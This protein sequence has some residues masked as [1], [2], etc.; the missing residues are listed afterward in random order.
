[1]IV[2]GE[3]LEITE[4]LKETTVET[5]FD[6]GT[7]IEITEETEPEIRR[8]E[9][10][11]TES[12]SETET[13][14][15]EE[16][17]PETQMTKEAETVITEET[18]SETETETETETEAI[19]ET[20]PKSETAAKETET[21]VTEET[22]PES[23]TQTKIQTPMMKAAAAPQARA[24]AVPGPT[25]S[26]ST[27]VDINN[28]ENIIIDIDDQ[29]RLKL[30]T[31]KVDGTDST[32]II[33]TN[34]S[35]MTSLKIN[36]VNQISFGESIN[37]ANAKNSLAMNLAAVILQAQKVLLV[38]EGSFTWN[39]KS[40]DVLAAPAAPDTLNPVTSYVE[41]TYKPHTYEVQIKNT[42]INASENVHIEATN[43]SRKNDSD[44]ADLVEID[45][46]KDSGW[47][48]LVNEAKKQLES[49]G[50]SAK[51][52]VNELTEANSF[53]VTVK[54]EIT[55]ILVENSS[56][57]SDELSLNTNT[58]VHVKTMGVGV[59]VA[60][61]VILADS[62]ISIKNSTLKAIGG[63]AAAV[64][65]K[66]DGTISIAAKSDINAIA[67]AKAKACNFGVA[68]TVVLG[69]TGVRAEGSHF[70]AKG[71]I[72]ISADNQT[73]S[74]ASATGQK[75][76]EKQSGIY[77]GVSVIDNDTYTMITDLANRNASMNAGGNIDIT[78]NR[79]GTTTTTACSQLKK[80]T[81]PVNNDV[82]ASITRIIAIA[83][84]SLGTVIIEKTAGVRQKV[85]DFFE[86]NVVLEKIKGALGSG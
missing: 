38:T 24:A 12:E 46:S 30:T 28:V 29:L 61:N 40:L 50:D 22:E 11:E 49:A 8:I 1:M 75:N 57:Q 84:Q 26:A 63:Q 39:V 31:Q 6:T 71:D 18:E 20:K 70:E 19:K 7:E 78:S 62:Q 67:D 16:T 23:E 86:D 25:E 32:S 44:E 54:P 77:V 3:E 36:A 60:V 66:P 79:H 9:E 85:S 64:N 15:S 43:T 80:F 35:A 48:E 33:C 53:F 5:E 4:S 17:E 73:V 58:K 51:E 76:N 65:G 2:H 45:T 13:E 59:G 21:S 68:V 74:T 52:A 14:I 83:K 55:S 37:Q 69:E 10:T 72:H 82:D 56:I 81:D 41:N 42:S 34:T 47:N 27:V